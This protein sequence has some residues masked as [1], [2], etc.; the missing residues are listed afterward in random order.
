MS[1]EREL[2]EQRREK[3]RRIEAL[4]YP[5]YPHRFDSTHTVEQIVAAYA[6]TSAEELAQSKPA[7]RVC[8]RLT[9]LRGHG[10]AGFADLSQSGCRLQVY[11]RKDAVGDRA[12]E[13]YQLLDL[14]D[15]AGVEGYLFRT[16]T[17]ELSVHVTDLSLLAKAMLPMPEK[18]HGLQDVE[19]RYRQR[20]LDLLANAEV[21]QT[22]R[23]RSKLVRALRAAM[24]R[25][26]YIEVET[27]MMQPLAGG[28]AARPFRTHHNALDIDLYLRIAPELYLKRLVVGG[29]DRVYE[30]NRNFRNEGISTQHNPEFTMLEFYQAYSDYRDLMDLTEQ[31]IPEVAFE[32]A[33]TATA[34]FGELTIDLTRFARYSLREAI[35]EFWPEAASRP[36]VEDFA[37]PP[38]A[39][40]VIETWNR[41]HP[42]QERLP[43]PA[44]SASAPGGASLGATVVALFEAVCER[45]LIQPT[46]I[47]DFPVELSPLAKSKDGEPGWVERFELYI[48][49]MEVANAYS[50]LND[51]EE[52]RR[53]FEM[54]AALRER[55][56]VEAHAMDEDYIRALCYGMPP[57][58]GEGIGVDR[59]AMLLT[60]SRSIRDVI[61][62]PLLRPEKSPGTTE[63]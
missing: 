52:Q 46:I 30:I 34:T 19:A 47:Y 16:K 27:P 44:E 11:V 15:C 40:A 55:G 53:R 5:A 23:T 8:G 17:G 7:V 56:D 33:G 12:F 37:D 59:L 63:E 41:L 51:P 42:G 20:Y 39:A 60:N 4:G 32:A 43:A 50:E 3:L 24:D 1:F 38:R 21:S 6:S 57:T 22:F 29:L 18:W 28:A 31:L 58:A 9:A 36:R 61:L 2:I 26:G 48:A 62:F 45:K 13:L 25:R 10:K 35:C 49:G 14:G 54:Q